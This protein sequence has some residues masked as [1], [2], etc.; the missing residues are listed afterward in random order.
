LGQDDYDQ[1]PNSAE[2]A[3]DYDYGSEQSPFAIRDLGNLGVSN[4]L[5]G[6]QT[7]LG[8][9]D[10]KAM[11]G[12]NPL[13]FL[14]LR[15]LLG[16]KEIYQHIAT[17]YKGLQPHAFDC[18][19]NKGYGYATRVQAE[20]D[21]DVSEWNG[22]TIKGY[23]ECMMTVLTHRRELKREGIFIADVSGTY[24]FT[25]STY[26]YAKDG[27]KIILGMYK[28]GKDL[29]A[30]NALRHHGVQQTFDHDRTTQ[31]M[32]A[33]TQLDKG[34]TVE[35]KFIRLTDGKARITTTA[36]GASTHF[37]GTKL[38][39]TYGEEYQFDS[40]SFPDQRLEVLERDGHKSVSTP[41]KTFFQELVAPQSRR[42]PW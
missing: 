25:F 1:P 2:S 5:P 3:D 37:T 6:A 12:L 33:T 24:L 42:Q 17:L 15:E 19:K 30:T 13:Q 38:G 20:D 10:H 23:N 39:Y 35:V 34:D 40:A 21:H 32:V 29:L 36:F 22:E 41:R 9:D 18:R 11:Y 14:H 8:P 7:K 27:G 31:T 26:M 16:I 28:N 4:E